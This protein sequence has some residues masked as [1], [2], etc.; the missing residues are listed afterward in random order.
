MTIARR[1]S[2]S[3]LSQL[4]LLSPKAVTPISAEKLLE[5]VNKAEYKKA[6]N[7]WQQDPA[8]M[9]LE[10][11]D[12]DGK[13]TTP[14][15]KAFFNLD[16]YTWKP[17]YEW[18]K[19]NRPE[20]V[21]AF[22]AQNE[23]QNDHADILPLVRHSYSL[24]KRELDWCKSMSHINA[25]VK[26]QIDQRNLLPWHMV[27]EMS[28]EDAVWSSS[29]NFNLPHPPYG[30]R[31]FVCQTDQWVD[32]DSENFQNSPGFIYRP[33][34]VQH[35]ELWDVK[36]MHAQSHEWFDKGKYAL[37]AHLQQ[38]MDVLIRLQN[39]RRMELAEIPPPLP[40]YDVPAANAPS[41]R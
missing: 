17:Y 26:L 12:K 35:A 37:S 23:A 7:I 21:D 30:G 11:T 34:N 15:K 2:E 3:S 9:L 14:L 6:R 1:N 24:L 41:M 20:L 38:D 19:I 5:Y 28:R 18:I 40:A 4:S 32:L 29:S 13:I 16:T 22:L 39:V 33:A 27:R 25:H 31:V 36:V 10:V 8:L